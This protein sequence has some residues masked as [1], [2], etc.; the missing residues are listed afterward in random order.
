MNPAIL[1]KLRLD[2][3]AMRQIAPLVV[4]PEKPQTIKEKVVDK[5]KS[6]WKKVKR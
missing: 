6:L 3:E 4:E 2:N 1:E 5:V